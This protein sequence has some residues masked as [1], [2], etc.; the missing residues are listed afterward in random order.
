MQYASG[1]PGRIFY[2]RF[3]HGEDLLTGL[4]TFIR[5][6]QIRSGMIHLIGAVSEVKM[7]TGPQETVLPPDQVWLNLDKAHE[8]VGIAV[9]RTGPQ[10]PSIHLHASVGSKSSSFTGCFRSEARVYILI[11]AVIT[12]FSGFEIGEITDEKTGLHLPDLGQITGQGI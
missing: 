3:D 11:E 9:I 6:H 10:G 12:E 2:L 5:D 7:V 1:T 8:L 4:R